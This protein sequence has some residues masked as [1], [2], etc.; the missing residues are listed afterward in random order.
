MKPYNTPV[1]SWASCWLHKLRGLTFSHQV[2]LD[3]SHSSH[4][5]PDA[6]GGKEN[7]ALSIPGKHSLVMNLQ[8]TVARKGCPDILAPGKWQHGEALGHE[9]SST[10]GLSNAWAVY[11]TWICLYSTSMCKCT[12]QI[13]EFYYRRRQEPLRFVESNYP[14]ASLPSAL[15]VWPDRRHRF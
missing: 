1:H 13:N 14:W 11:L 6:Q 10:R 9:T 8:K 12:E 4:I 3:T 5:T 15:C 7:Q 2:P